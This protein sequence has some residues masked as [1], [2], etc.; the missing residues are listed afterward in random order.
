M[1][2]KL[3]IKIRTTENTPVIHAFTTEDPQE[4]GRRRR[5]KLGK[6]IEKKK[7]KKKSECETP[8]PRQGRH[9]KFYCTPWTYDHL[10]QTQW[11]DFYLYGM[12]VIST[13]R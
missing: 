6:S 7:K 13:N 3:Q 12:E 10:N 11:N 9:A 5:I 4:T 8:T 2:P 1:H